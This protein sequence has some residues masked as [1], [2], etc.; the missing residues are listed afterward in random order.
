MFW[1]VQLLNNSNS[2]VLIS[3]E[4]FFFLSYNFINIE[5]V[6]YTLLINH[7]LENAWSLSDSKLN[8][9]DHYILPV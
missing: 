3:V 6:D 9:E 8:A 5:V 1:S 7:R 2:T 4:L